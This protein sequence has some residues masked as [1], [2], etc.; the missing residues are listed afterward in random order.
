MRKNRKNGFLIN[1]FRE[2]RSNI[3]YTDTSKHSKRKNKPFTN[4]YIDEYLRTT[5]SFQKIYLTDVDTLNNIDDFSIFDTIIIDDAHISTANKYSKIFNSGGDNCQLIVFGDGDFRSSVT[6]VFIRRID[7]QYLVKLKKRYLYLSLES[8]N[9]WS[10]DN[11]FIYDPAKKVEI[12][13]YDSIEDMVEASILLFE[14]T[15]HSIGIMVKNDSIKRMVYSTVIKTL[16]LSYEYEQTMTILNEKIK[17]IMI[18]KESMYSLDH[19]YVWYPDILDVNEDLKAQ[20]IRNYIFAEKGIHICYKN[21]KSA[22]YLEPINEDISKH[23]LEVSELNP[24]VNG[25]IITYIFDSLLKAGLT[26][27]YG[28][29]LIDLVIRTYNDK[30]G[31]IILGKRKDLRYSIIDDYI[32]YTKNY[33]EKGWKI[34]IYSMEQ[35]YKSYNDTILDIKRLVENGEV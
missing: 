24:F 29:G 26:P 18:G 28:P 3:K 8:K 4:L 2:V 34:L 25:T 22:K 16:R 23:I 13:K 21:T 17:I 12:E 35:F 11:Q 20:Y 6:N 31:I 32:F 7:E 27:E 15:N 9:T 5:P 30:Y 10:K 14:T 19:I 33:T 1:L